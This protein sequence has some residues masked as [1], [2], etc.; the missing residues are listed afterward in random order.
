VHDEQAELPRTLV[1]KIDKVVVLAR[2]EHEHQGRAA[3]IAKCAE[4]PMV[5]GPDEAL[6]CSTAPAVDAM[7]AFAV[8]L[9][10]LRRLER[11]HTEAFAFEGKDLPTGHAR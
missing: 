11:D 1:G 6:R 7:F 4:E 5:V 10:Q 9:G 8:G 2:L 3:G